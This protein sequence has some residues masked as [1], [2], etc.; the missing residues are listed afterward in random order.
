MNRPQVFAFLLA[1]V[2][3]TSAA[4]GIV[5]DEAVDGELSGDGATPTL[6]IVAEG[7]NVWR[8]EVGVL[9]PPGTGQPFDTDLVTFTVPDGLFLT[10]LRLN[11]YDEQASVANG[12]FLAIAAGDSVSIGFGSVHLANAL[13]D[14]LGEV[15]DDLE[16]GSAFP[17]PA[18]ISTGLTAPLP[19]GDY[20]VWMSEVD[21]PVTYELVATL[22]VPEP[23]ALGGIAFALIAAAL[24]SQGMFVNRRRRVLAGSFTCFWE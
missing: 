20:V 3:A 16:L 12:S 11:Q 2:G 23:T 4:A 14:S 18:A 17:P 9:D 13:V 7:E 19:P 1:T 15:L 22:A 21:G 8:G 6:L 24:R 5:W 10:S